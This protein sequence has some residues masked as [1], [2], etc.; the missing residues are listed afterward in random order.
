MK[1][2]AALIILQY[3]KIMKILKKIFFF[4]W[5]NIYLIHIKVY[6]NTKKFAMSIHSSSLCERLARCLFLNERFSDKAKNTCIISR[7]SE[8]KVQIHARTG[9]DGPQAEK[10]NSPALSLTSLLFGGWVENVTPPPFYPRKKKTWWSL[11][12]RRDGSRGRSGKVWKISSLPGFD[13]RTFRGVA[14]CYTEWATAD[15]LGTVSF[16]IFHCSTQS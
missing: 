1:L 7:Q 9:H 15:R 11:Y 4:C 6:K 8:G 12:R 2:L 14:S 10:R 16:L 13:P 5:K 3:L